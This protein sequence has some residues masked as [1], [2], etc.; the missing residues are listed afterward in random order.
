MTGFDWKAASQA[1]AIRRALR[2]HAADLQHAGDAHAHGADESV[3]TATH[4][5]HHIEIRTGYRITVDG[6]PFA[7]SAAVNNGG[8]VHY[9]GLPTRDYASTVDLVKDAIDTFPDDFGDSTPLAEPP[10]GDQTGAQHVRG[11]HT[12]GPHEH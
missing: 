11:D 4:H 3:R 8:R 1:E 12:H 6:R 5:G 9:H 2:Q 7:I 10:H